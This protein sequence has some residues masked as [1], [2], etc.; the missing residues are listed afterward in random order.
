ML[1]EEDNILGFYYKNLDQRL[2]LVFYL[3][4]RDFILVCVVIDEEDIIDYYES[5]YKKN[6]DGDIQFINEILSEY[7]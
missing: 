2:D 4:L 3:R 7:N 1:G 6:Y 5:S